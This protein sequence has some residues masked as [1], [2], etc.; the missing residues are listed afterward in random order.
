MAT[1][2]EEAAAKAAADKAKEDEG[3]V[4]LAELTKDMATL[5]TAVQGI[6]Q[7]MSKLQSQPPKREDE[8]ADEGADDEDEDEVDEKTLESLPRKGFAEHII[9]KVSKVVEKQLK[10][11]SKSASDV[12]DEVARGKVEAAVMEVVKDHKDFWDWKD[13]IRE[14][15]DSSPGISPKR[16]YQLAR[17][18]NSEKAKKMDEKYK[19]GE[20][21][22]AGDKGSV[23]E[24]KKFGGFTPTSGTTQ[25]NSKMSKTEAADKAWEETMG[26]LGTGEGT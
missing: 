19:V 10:S 20:G 15:A 26:S 11:V 3:K 8:D 4:T 5:A 6:Q 12:K 21:K 17:M 2:E 7:N 22:G 18:E 9:K 16:A 24:K 1:P 23:K 14:I 13:E 25:Q